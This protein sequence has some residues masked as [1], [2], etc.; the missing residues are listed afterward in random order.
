MKRKLYKL[1]DTLYSHYG[2]QKWWPAKTKFEVIVGAILTQNTSWKNAEKAIKKLA[3]A[4]LLN[5]R[6]MHKS[7]KKRI[8]SLIRPAGYYN[9]KANRLKNFI[10]FLF[11][12]YGGNLKKMFSSSM[13]DLRS[14]LLGVRGLGPETVDSILLYAGGKPVFVVDAYTKR[15]LSRHNLI[16][17]GERYEKVQHLFM[18]NLRP[19]TRLFNE[20]HALLVQLAKD[21]CNK[22]PKCSKCPAKRAL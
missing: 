16:S 22:N 14:E 12:K 4:K 19:D 17:E 7:G 18:E 1:Y 11:T 21:S 8:A 6:S 3:E 5:P 10:D 2:P 13:E 9:V 20:Y 15:I